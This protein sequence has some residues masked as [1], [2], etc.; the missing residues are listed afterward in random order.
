[1]ETYAVFKETKELPALPFELKTKKWGTVVV[2]AI[3][4]TD[5]GG[6]VLI[7]ENDHMPFWAKAL[8]VLGHEV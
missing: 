3:E 2:E 8:D 1:M 4:H 7:S 5:K 6:L